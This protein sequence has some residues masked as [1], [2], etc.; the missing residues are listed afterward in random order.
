MN[1][2]I[3]RLVLPDTLTVEGVSQNC[4]TRLLLCCFV[5]GDKIILAVITG[6]TTV[7]NLPV[8]HGG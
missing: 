5:V 6:N 2:S 1:F 4:S 8:S 3:V 7:H